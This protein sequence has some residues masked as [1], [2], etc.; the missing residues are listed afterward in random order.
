MTDFKDKKAYTTYIL[1]GMNLSVFALEIVSGGSQNLETLYQLGALSPE[2]VWLGEWWRVLSANFLHFGWLHLITN[3]LGLYFLGQFV[4]LAIG[5]SRYL[6]IYLIS[7]TGSMLAFSVLAIKFGDS[8]QLLVGASAAIMGLVGVIGAM[9][10]R[11]WR[12]EK[13][14]TAT[15]RLRFILLVIVLQFVFDL[16]T[17]QVSF[18][19]HLLGLAIGSIT[20]YLVLI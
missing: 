20:G 10:F 12:K 2:E 13:S 14:R 1:I 6:F 16:T 19:S 15:K 7:G 5:I 8:Q 3:M 9:F 18:L 11:D 4:E 17:P